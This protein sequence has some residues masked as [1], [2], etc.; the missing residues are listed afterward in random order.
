MIPCEYNGE[1]TVFYVFFPGLFL[2]AK[3][4]LQLSKTYVT[5]HCTQLAQDSLNY[6]LF[7]YIDL[8]Y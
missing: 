2:L 3:R 4:P 6:P 5:C 7:S 8:Y 1:I